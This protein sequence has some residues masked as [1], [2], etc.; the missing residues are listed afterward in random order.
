MVN[1]FVVTEIIKVVE[2]F[3]TTNIENRLIDH[4]IEIVAKTSMDRKDDI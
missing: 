2:V 3:E 1:V 4:P